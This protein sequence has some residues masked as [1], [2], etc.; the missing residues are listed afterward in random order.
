MDDILAFVG[1]VGEKTVTIILFSAIGLVAIVSVFLLILIFLNFQLRKKSMD[2]QYRSEVAERFGLIIL[3][4]ATVLNS[5]GKLLVSR[6]ERARQRCLCCQP[7]LATPATH[8]PS[9]A[10]V[11]PRPADPETT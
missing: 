7:K 11:L 2:Y 6:E 1:N 8:I 3:D 5:E 9:S 10:G 4:D